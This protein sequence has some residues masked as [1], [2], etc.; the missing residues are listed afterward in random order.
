MILDWTEICAHLRASQILSFIFDDY[1]FEQV[2]F[3][4]KIF[5]ADRLTEG[6]LSGGLGRLCI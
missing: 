6:L 4:P 3:L 1:F 5:L 2:V